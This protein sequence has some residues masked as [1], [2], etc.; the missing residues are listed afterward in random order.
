MHEW[1]KKHSG[2]LIR[3]VYSEAFGSSSGHYIEGH[4]EDCE[5]KDYWGWS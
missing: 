2:H 4:C 1:I 5:E 3:M